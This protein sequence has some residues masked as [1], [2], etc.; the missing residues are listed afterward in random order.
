[1]AFGD[2]RTPLRRTAM[3]RRR[4][5]PSFT[6]TAKGETL[7]RNCGALATEPHHAVP[8]S[9][10]PAGRSDLRNCLPL[11]HRCH[12]A[13]HNGKPIPRS[14]FTPDEWAFIATIGTPTFLDKRYP[15]ER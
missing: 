3:K 9:L 13:W 5:P 11:C 14:V 7:C 2:Q 15:N 1:M 6:L 4:T 8:R 10:S 12:T